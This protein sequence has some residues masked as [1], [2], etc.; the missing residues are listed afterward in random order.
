MRCING[1]FLVFLMLLTFG[2]TISFAQPYIRVNQVGFLQTDTKEAILMKTDSSD[3]SAWSYRIRNGGQTVYSNASFSNSRTWTAVG[4]TYY[5]ALFDFSP[6][7]THGTTY[8]IDA[9]SNN[10]VCATSSNFAIGGTLYNDILSDNL[11]F[12]REQ[13]CGN[14]FNVPG[15]NHCHEGRAGAG[16]SN[17]Y[18]GGWHDA[19]D[20]IKFT[21]TTAFTVDMMLLAFHLNQFEQG[22]SEGNYFDDTV[23]ADGANGQD[24]IPDILNE[25][26][27][28]LDFLLKVFPASNTLVYQIADYEDHNVGGGALE[29]LPESDATATIPRPILVTNNMGTNLLGKLL[30]AYSYGAI[31]FGDST[32][33]YYNASFAQ[34]CR[35]RADWCVWNLKKKDTVQKVETGGDNGS[36]VPY[37]GETRWDDDYIMG[38]R[39]YYDL[40]GD[41]WAY[42]ESQLVYGNQGSFSYDQ[43]QI[44][45]DYLIGQDN[46]VG[47]YMNGVESKIA[48]DAF[49]FGADTSLVGT[50]ADALGYSIADII[51]DTIAPDN[52]DKLNARRQRDYMLGMNPWGVSFV[53]GSG[54]QKV[55]NPHHFMSP[56]GAGSGLPV[57]SL[58]GGPTKVSNDAYM[59]STG[60]G[61]WNTSPY[62]DFNA[63]NTTA[64]VHYYDCMCDFDSNEPSI[65]YTSMMLFCSAYYACIEKSGAYAPRV[66]VT[67][68]TPLSDAKVIH[69]GDKYN[70]V[71]RLEI[72][73]TAASNTNSAL[74]S[75]EYSLDGINWKTI[76]P[77]SYDGSSYPVT[78]TIDIA[79]RL[80]NQGV[81]YIY[82]RTENAAGYQ[83][84]PEKVYIDVDLGNVSKSPLRVYGIAQPANNVPVFI[85]YKADTRVQAFFD[86]TSTITVYTISG[87]K[88]TD[89]EAQFVGDDY[90]QAVWYGKDA[91]GTAVGPGIYLVSF[92]TG[93][94]KKVAKVIVK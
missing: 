81:S 5:C 18:D 22:G 11:R 51:R 31:I 85:T 87:E 28:G 86:G 27:W 68:K 60:A 66:S 93:R 25:A 75:V 57:G 23:V 50:C 2:S 8:R 70:G 74:T 71:V 44:L 35:Q 19:G 32:K 14:V 62:N 78:I 42:A 20:Y 53:V 84:A 4:G 48:S 26:K 43:V 83:S 80:L 56:G 91:D 61:R 10:I 94:F 30:T 15:R 17:A 67:M 92:K 9:L 37:Y 39:A 63:A 58:V 47:S 69:N 90:I 45:V 65:Y 49:Y 41:S 21:V 82:I 89:I 64:G 1:V 88:V 13:R 3:F 40:T 72:V 52:S 73:V 79:T 6:V 7:I 59:G 33:S 38:V 34:Q 29:R 24:T 76:N 77:E 54:A 55:A 36:S 16:Y 12:Y 46:V